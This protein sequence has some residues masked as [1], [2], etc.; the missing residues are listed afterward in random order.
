MLE[1]GVWGPELPLLLELP[2][3]VHWV[4]AAFPLGE[5]GP[6]LAPHHRRGMW[7]QGSTLVGKTHLMGNDEQRLVPNM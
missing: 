7:G 3:G 6:V 1:G 4:N 2:L 5:V